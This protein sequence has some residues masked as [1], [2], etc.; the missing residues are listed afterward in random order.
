[1]IVWQDFATWARATYLPRA[2]HVQLG[3]ELR[4]QLELLEQGLK[5]QQKRLEVDASSNQ[6]IMYI[7]QYI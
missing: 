5:E 7:I 6:Y 4:G 3:E 2:Q 1:M